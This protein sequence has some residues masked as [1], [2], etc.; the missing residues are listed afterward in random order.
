MRLR[1][2]IAKKIILF[3]F[4]VIFILLPQRVYA[5][6]EEKICTN[7][8]VT[9]VNPVRGRSMWIDK[10]LKPIQDQYQDLMK[11]DFPATWLLQYDAI[12][13][14][15]VAEYTK[16]F[17]KN[18]EIGIFLEVSPKLAEKA[19][20]IYPHATSWAN[21]SAIFLSGYTQSERRKIIDTL[22][23]SFNSTYG[24][25]PKSVGAWWIDSYSLNFMKEKYGITSAMIV[26]DQKTT[27]HYGVWGQWW[28]FPYFSSKENILVPAQKN[29]INDGVA[30]IQ[31]AQRH[32]DIAYGD[33]P[34]FSNYSFQAND[35]LRQ[36]RDTNFFKDL[37]DIYLGCNTNPI[38]QITIGLETGMEGFEFRQEYQK[39]LAFLSG[40]RD[41]SFVS[42]SRFAD[43]YRGIYPQID[44][45]TLQG[46]K[47]KWLLNTFERINYELGD[48]I[49]YY[50]TNSFS[51]YFVRDTS[52]FLNRRLMNGEI[53]VDNETNYPAFV[54]V[55][56]LV[57]LIFIYYR[58]FTS[59]LLGNLFLVSAFG[60][61]LKSG[62]LY[63][64]IVYYGTVVNKLILA[65]SLVV[66]FSLV[67]FLFIKSKKLSLY[68]ILSFGLDYLI[69]ILRY[70]YFSG[71]Y[72]F[73]IAV[74]AL[75]FVGFKFSKPFS[76]EFLNTDFSSVVSASL[77][78]LDFAKIWNSS[79]LSL[80]FYPLVHL[81]FGYVLYLISKRLSFRLRIIFLV[82][83]VILYLLY[84]MAIVYAD[85]RIV[86]KN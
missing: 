17:D 32:P 13:D 63:G 39:Q 44:K 18:Q 64:W 9:F 70:S 57:S 51:D 52:S 8:F 23:Y 82:M 25:F 24:Y 73:G 80:L 59:W 48:N 14:T 20:V 85:P 37:T 35:Y 27:D 83:L 61:L 4:F 50:Q 75:R 26:A 29:K 54:I 69:S 16:K 38:G 36:G 41:L 49:K 68:I 67:L 28:G 76:I 72:Y 86:I 40:Y 11:Y 7:R 65:Q 79:V 31:W 1:M 43:V 81:I 5:E 33:G 78:R 22:F 74:D 21:P 12:S 15:E 62:E 47:T 56:L 77:L 66:V 2:S 53:A 84:L 10:T 45:I 71:S 58:K 30:V 60:L 3:I 19:R 34:I 46:P 6:Q 55:W 42:M